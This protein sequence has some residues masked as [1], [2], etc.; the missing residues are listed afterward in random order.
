MEL[1]RESFYALLN[2]ASFFLYNHMW[3]DPQSEVDFMASVAVCKLLLTA[4]QQQP[5]VLQ[6]CLSDS[7]EAVRKNTL[8]PCSHWLTFTQEIFEGYSQHQNL[9]C[10]RFCGCI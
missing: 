10:F 4:A 5:D 3:S 2:D 6:I 1:Y 8:L 7:I 9:D